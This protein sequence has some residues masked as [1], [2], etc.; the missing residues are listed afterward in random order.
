MN[1][2]NLKLVPGTTTEMSF[3]TYP[4]ADA[5]FTITANPPSVMSNVA[6]SGDFEDLT[7]KPEVIDIHDAPLIFQDANHNEISRFTANSSTNVTVV[8][9]TH[10][11]IKWE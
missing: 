7:D 8:L 9:P 2:V 1:T 4:D 3:P 11:V 10:K 5:N 6:Y